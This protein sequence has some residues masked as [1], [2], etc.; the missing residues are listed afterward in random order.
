MPSEAGNTVIWIVDNKSS[1]NGRTPTVLGEPVVT[2]LEPGP[3][4]CF[5]GVD[6]G[7]IFQENPLQGRAAF[8]VEVL[9]R[10]DAAGPAEQR[11]V[12]LQ[13]TGSENRAM[14]ETRVAANSFYLDTFLT[15]NGAKVTLAE[16][17]LS[18]PTSSFHWAALSYANGRM[19]Q[20]MNGVEELTGELGF[21][22]LGPGQMSLGVRLNRKHWF[23]GCIRELRFT[24]SALPAERLQQLRAP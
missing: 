1:V 5:D 2:R 21:A 24:S 3:A 17:T 11:F 18:H 12:H 10:P 6:D 4:L 7:L 16:P 22:P 8:T 14:I 19:R 23:K 20:F 15:S 13:E 9:F